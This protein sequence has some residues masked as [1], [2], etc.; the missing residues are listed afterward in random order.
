MPPFEYIDT[1][2]ATCANVHVDVAIA[3]AGKAK[4]E[5]YKKRSR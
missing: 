2:Y 1:W 3:G 5:E 4:K